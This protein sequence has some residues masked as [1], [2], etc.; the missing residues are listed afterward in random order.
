M[1]NQFSLKTFQIKWPRICKASRSACLYQNYSKAFWGKGY[2]KYDKQFLS[3]PATRY[4]E[5]IIQIMQC[6]ICNA[7]LDTYILLK[8]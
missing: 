2:L 5:S 6:R 4:T 8:L 7:Y 3:I 1:T